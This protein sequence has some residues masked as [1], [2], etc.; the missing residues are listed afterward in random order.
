MRLIL[1]NR[2]SEVGVASVPAVP[3][4]PSSPADDI[5]LRG[6]DGQPPQEGDI[7]KCGLYYGASTLHQ[8][9]SHIASSAAS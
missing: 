1:V 7:K 8:C 9:S 2:P 3:S 6:T 5:V 4:S